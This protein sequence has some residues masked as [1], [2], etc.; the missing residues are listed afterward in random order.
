MDRKNESICEVASSHTLQ[1][2]RI[3]DVFEI[4][5]E[6][7]DL[8]DAED[9]V[10]ARNTL[11]Q[12]LDYHET[13]RIPYDET[14]NYFIRK[15]GLY[16]YLQLDT[17]SWQERVAFESFKADIGEDELVTLHRE[18]SSVLSKLLHGN[19]VAVSAPTSFGKSF[20]IDSFISI[21]KPKN[22]VIIVPTIAL[23]DETRRRLHKKFSTEY[24]II[25]TA[26]VE[27]SKKNIFIFPQERAINYADK[28][29][30]IDIL[31]IDEFYK[32][33]SKFDK[34]RSP[35][36]LRAILKLGRKSTQ[37]YFLAP[38]ITD[39]KGNLFTE[40]MEFISLNFNTVYLEKNELYREILGDES[41]KNKALLET[42]SSTQGKTL[43]YAGTF[44]NINKISTVLIAEHRESQ[45]DLIKSFVQWLSKNYTV[46]WNLAQLVR[47]STGIHNGQLHRSLSQIQVKLF[48]EPEGLKNI[49]STSS[50]IEGVNTSAEN[51]VLWS[52]MSG[53]GRAKI[54]DFTYKNIIGRGG[55]MFKHF[56]GKIFILD[57]PPADSQIELELSLPD[58]IIGDIDDQV[59]KKELTR[60]QIIKIITYKDEM[61]ELFGVDRFE[62]LQREGVFQNSDSYFI[63]NIAK[64]IKENPDTWAGIGYLNSKNS[65]DWDSILYRALEHQ[66][67][68]GIKF[69]KFVAFVKI[70]SQN[71]AKSI[72]ELLSELDEYDL[73][74]EE[75]FKLERNVA[76]GLS[77]LLGD[78]NTINV[79]L[80]GDRAHDISPFI[81]QTSHAFLPQVVYELEEYGLPRMISQKIH[82]DGIID[83]EADD[84]VIHDA[85]SLFNDS[86]IK[87]RIAEI[88]ELDSF[89][90]YILDY[91]Y[92]GITYP[93]SQTISA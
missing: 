23:T 39:L 76:F 31:V 83:F 84:L 92:E 47:R 60:E 35:A 17:A 28:I 54:N 7:N 16:P 56:V 15:L 50:I 38:N 69:G 51:V 32:A 65:S 46:N 43:I 53:R 74:I 70:L 40:G 12:A 3:M 88:K 91:F 29:E 86:E 2:I 33:S 93:Q 63:L 49:V 22:I 66:N 64:E 58:E 82:D 10:S 20:I 81:S 71:W 6:V 77:A 44:T 85:I 21:K 90:Y 36:L 18:Q 68:A 55:R 27:L 11:I 57:E 24:K 14:L 13:N 75:F 89:D 52:N 62:K 34:E 30:N 42:L 4:C 37:R 9:E 26:D 61:S 72:P 1:R 67:V 78:I 87:H 59:D 48:E 5:Q 79:L 25:T 19:D 73:G 41:K 80:L 8:I 45:S